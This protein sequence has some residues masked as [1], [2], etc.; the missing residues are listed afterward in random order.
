MLKNSMVKHM[1]TGARVVRGL[2]WKWRDQVRFTRILP[3]LINDF[4]SNQHCEA[5]GDQARVV[6]GLDA[7]HSVWRGCV[8]LEDP[9]R[10]FN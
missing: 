4:Q 6:R 5:Y 2:D 3:P 9:Q 10:L 7:E 8:N 1:V